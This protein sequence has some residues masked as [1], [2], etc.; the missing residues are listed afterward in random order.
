MRLLALTAATALV[1]AFASPQTPLVLA[2]DDTGAVGRPFQ[3][4]AP[5]GSDN[6]GHRERSEGTERSDTAA[7]DKGETRS[8]EAGETTNRGRSERSQV[9]HRVVIHK[10][11]HHLA[12]FNWPRHHSVIHRRGRRFVA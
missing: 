6:R 12:A 8:G 10:R 3:L 5:P 1:L 9:R 7:S 4:Y 11:G 2:H